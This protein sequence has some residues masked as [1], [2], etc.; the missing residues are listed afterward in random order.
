MTFVVKTE[1]KLI[2]ARNSLVAEAGMDEALVDN[3]IVSGFLGACIEDGF[4][5]V[6]EGVAQ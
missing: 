2:E 5:E 4:L 3:A 6:V 1:Q